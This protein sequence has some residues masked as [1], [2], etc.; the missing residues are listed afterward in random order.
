[1]E[2]TGIRGFEMLS[3]K[4]EIGVRRSTV[5]CLVTEMCALHVVVCSRRVSKL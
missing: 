3:K 2:D 1:M 4:L 5:Q